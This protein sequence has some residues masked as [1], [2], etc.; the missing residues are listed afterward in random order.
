MRYDFQREL[1]SKLATCNYRCVGCDAINSLYP[2]TKAI[3][4]SLGTDYHQR[5]I[6]F[7]RG[8]QKKDYACTAALTDVKGDRSKRPNEQKEM[9]VR[10][11]ERNEEGIIVSGAKISQSGAFAADINFFL[12]AQFLRQGEEKFAIAFAL[13][14]EDEGVK[15]VLQNTGYQAKLREGGEFEFGNRYGDRTTCMVILE[16]V[17][18]PWER[19]FIFENLKSIRDVLTLFAFSHMAAR[20]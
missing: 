17:L 2:T 16:K 13:K 8:I 7:L 5:F 14:P 19:V 6:K 4:E 3:D 9:F 11:V 12:P 10:V 20:A 15:Y 18:V 1:S